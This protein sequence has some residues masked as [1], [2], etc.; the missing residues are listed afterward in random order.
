MKNRITVQIIFSYRG[1]TYQPSAT[2]E[3]DRYLE[4]NQSIPDFLPI[5]A[6]ENN[7]D[8]YSYEYEVMQMG[9]YQY[10]DAEGLV[11]DFCNLHEFDGAGFAA[12]WKQQNLINQLAEIAHK[13]LGVDDLS[14]QQS[15]QQALLEA[16][17]L[18]VRSVS[19]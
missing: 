4:K 2:I 17:K 1:T 14:T 10:L 16:Y 6:K 7:I 18:G 11:G 3:L 19:P 12:A 5:V 9:E 8:S 13:Q 15:L